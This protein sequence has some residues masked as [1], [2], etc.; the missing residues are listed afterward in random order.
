MTYIYA[1]W[2][3]FQIFVDHSDQVTIPNIL[4]RIL[5]WD[6]AVHMLGVIPKSV[7]MFTSLT[8]IMKVQRISVANRCVEDSLMMREAK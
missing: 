1:L 5:S 6:V 2:R 8:M 3:N 7:I 4:Y